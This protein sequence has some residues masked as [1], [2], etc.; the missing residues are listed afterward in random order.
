MENGL[1]HRFRAENGLNIR[2]R[3]L[4]PDDVHH[5]VDLFEHLGPDSRYRRFNIPL[6]D[7]DPDVIW[8]EAQAMADLDPA[9][10]Q[11]WLAFADLP[12]QPDACV[13]GIRSIRTNGD[14]AEVSLAV[15]DDVQGV[16]IG[17]ELLKLVGQQAYDAGVHK[18]V[19]HV[20]SGNRPLWRSLRHLGAPIEREFQGAE[21]YVEVDLEEASRRGL[22]AGPPTPEGG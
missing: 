17:T 8:Q 4:R 11:G 3:P 18:L 10:G 13:A 2:V 7:P 9:R 20:Q 16:R 1:T 6:P 14:V 21:A 19:G 5:L 22:L 15:R 12:G